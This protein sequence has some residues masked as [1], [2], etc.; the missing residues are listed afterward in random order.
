MEVDFSSLLHK[1]EILSKL[2]PEGVRNAL[3]PQAAMELDVGGALES[4]IK[5]LRK[6]YPAAKG[7]M[8]LQDQ[9]QTIDHVSMD[10][11]MEAM[12]HDFF[13]A[14]PVIGTSS[15]NHPLNQS[16]QPLLPE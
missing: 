6:R 4:E 2:P 3:S 14:Q 11:G 9:Q 12:V 1:T 8:I 13:T 5:E 15:R 16:E 10:P 7:R